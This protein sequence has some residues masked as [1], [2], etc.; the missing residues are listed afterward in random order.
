MKN[1]Y[2]SLWVLVCLVASTA[3]AQDV[4]P[5]SAQKTIVV[6]IKI[7]DMEARTPEAIDEL[8]NDQKRWNQLLSEG[9][10]KLIASS[11]ILTLSGERSMVRIGQRVPVQT[12]SLPAFRPPK[13]DATTNQPSQAL[14]E[15]AVGIPQIQYEN[16]GLNLEIQPRLRQD[17]TID[18][19]FKIEM[20]GLTTDTGRLTPTFLTR[21]LSNLIKIK[22]NQ[23][24][25][26]FEVY[27]NELLWTPLAQA[28][29]NNT[30]RGNFFIVLSA[31]AIE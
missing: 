14:N 6:D 22:Q 15:T 10:V 5:A 4:N 26:I 24:T 28:N 16:T 19:F 21:T 8:T 2:A 1:I 25:M 20:T 18:M 23:P 29:S 9:K 12:H 7:V 17:S 13:N 27:Q 30:Q 31:K 11:K 3:F